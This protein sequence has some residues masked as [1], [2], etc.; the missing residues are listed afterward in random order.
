MNIPEAFR[1]KSAQR[2]AKMVAQGIIKRVNA[3][4]RW[5]SGLSAV[6]KGNSDFRLVVNMVGPN[7]AIRRRFYKLP[8]LDDIKTKLK[9]ARYFT[10]LDLTSAFHHFRIGEESSDTATPRS[11]APTACTSSCG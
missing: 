10:K 8:L 5:V 3:A 4:P 11:W 7:R 1:D 9:G 6:P 2:L